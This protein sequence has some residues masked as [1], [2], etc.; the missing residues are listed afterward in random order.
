MIY[1]LQYMKDLLSMGPPVYFVLKA[2]LNY[3]DGNIQNLVCGG[4]GCNADS[5]STHLFRA[6]LSPER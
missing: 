2:G 6:H 5:L 1:L 3:S 4:T